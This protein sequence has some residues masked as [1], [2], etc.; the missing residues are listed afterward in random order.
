MGFE[1]AAAASIAATVIG[2]AV[3]AVGA[4]QQGNAAANTA[5]YQAE[6][7][8]A[9]AEAQRYQMQVANNNA[10]TAQQNAAYERARAANEAEIQDQKSRAT[11]GAQLAGMAASGFDVNTGS[12]VDIRD[13]TKRLGRLDNLS[14]RQAGELSA[15]EFDQQSRNDKASAALYGA[16][17]DNSL[18]EASFRRSQVSDARTAGY[19]GAFSSLLGTASSVGTK[20]TNYKAAG[21]KG[22]T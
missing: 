9:A 10:V 17:A 15:R 12:A 5:R 3:S 18:R 21:V 1:I 19:L 7:A 11:M 14:V 4:I 2:G 16:G 8:N 20:W 6:A 22:F 13:S